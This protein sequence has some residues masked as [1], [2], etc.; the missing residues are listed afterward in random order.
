MAKIIKNI[1]RNKFR[2]HSPKFK[3][4]SRKANIDASFLGSFFGDCPHR[5][6]I[7]KRYP[8]RK[9]PQGAMVTRIA[10]SPTGFMHIGSIY[11][12]LISERF[13]HQTNGVYFLRIEDTDKKRE[14]KDAY[15]IIIESLD[16]FN[17]SPD[18]G[19]DINGKEKGNYGPYRQ[20]KRKEIYKAFIKYLIEIG[21]AYP[22]FCTEEELEEMRREQEKLKVRTGYY[23]KWAKWRE[24]DEEMVKK[25][26]VK[27]K[28][29]VIRFKSLGNNK[30]KFI[31]NDL[32][33]GWLELPEND[34]DVV[35]MKSD[36][37]PTY[38]FA[39]VI[40][41]YLMGTTHIFRGDEWLSSVPIHYEL[42]EALNLER[43]NYGHIAP[44]NK[45]DESGGKRKLS[46][47]KDPEANISFYD[48]EGYPKIAVI[49]Y[50]MN[51]ANSDFEDWRKNNPDKPYTE[52][53]L[54][55]KGLSASN[56]PLFDKIK[57]DDIS[58][59][60]ISKIKAE[61]VYKEVLAWASKYDN[62]FKRILK[63]DKKY[64]LAIFSI[65]R[66]G[67]KPRKD[68]SHWSEVKDTFA[69]FIKEKFVPQDWA[70][71]KSVLQSEEI[72]EIIGQYKKIFDF[73]DSREKWLEKIKQIA[74]NFNFA[75]D[76]KTYKNNKDKYRGHIGEIAQVIRFAITGRTKTPDLYQIM[77]ILG[78]EECK[79]R[80]IFK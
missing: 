78:E 31:H 27:N 57:L 37:L 28:P 25:M 51:L 15:K 42:F 52:F 11:T 24:A 40:D 68:I 56:G 17:L 49:E 41:D 7:F 65:E 55:L 18:E 30:N 12:A 39:H 43:P 67:E 63:K 66:G 76:I 58:K 14:I 50:L 3:S 69:F 16:K 71:F 9:L 61:E 23:G 6:E 19:E 79:K 48:K 5:E 8:K 34:L 74:A 35:I 80:L 1:K 77:Q 53:K 13:A 59:E 26:L 44:I 64:W 21:R 32:I 33:K 4:S 75:P 2:V 54:S 70:N 36:G 10:P 72:K 22:C 20:S 29:Y 46:K 45:I 47:R 62:D 73:N 60:I 38:H